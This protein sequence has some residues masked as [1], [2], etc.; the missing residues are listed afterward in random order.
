VD[1]SVER[2]QVAALTRRKA[3][4]DPDVLRTALQAIDEAA[5]SGAN[6]LYP[7]KHAL[8]SGASVGEISDVLRLVFGVYRPAR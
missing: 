2:E 1:P 4:R 7:M 8:S 5:R 6:L 3:A